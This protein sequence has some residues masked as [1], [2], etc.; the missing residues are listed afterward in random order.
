MPVLSSFFTSQAAPGLLLYGSHDPWLV[1]LSVAV[2]MFSSTM[3][4]QAAAQAGSMPTRA[5]RQFTLFAGALALGCGVWA[6]HFI[7]M[8]SFRLCTT[9]HYDP[10]TT[11]L[12][13]LPSLAA[14]W[15]ALDLLSREQVSRRQLG[16]G[17]LL[18]GGG[19]GAMHYIGM[20]A[21]QMAAAL[22]YDPL[23]FAVSIVVAVSLAVLALWV[24][25]GVRALALN[26]LSGLLQ[27]IISG[28]AMGLAIAGMHYTGMA[29]ARFIGPAQSATPMALQ[30]ALNIALS[31]TLVSF[32][33]TVLVAGATGLSRYRQLIEQLQKKGA[34]LRA[35]SNS[36]LD[37][38]IV[39]NEQG[40]IQDFNPGAQRIFG[41]QPA[42]VIGQKVSMLMTPT[43]RA[44]AEADFGAFMQQAYGVMDEERDTRACHRDQH[45]ISIRLVV[46]RMDVPGSALYVAFVSDITE[47]LRMASELQD[48]EAQFRSLIANIP[49]ISYRCRMARGWPMVFISDAV[50]GITGYPAGDFLGPLASLS[51]TDLVPKADVA[52]VTAIVDEAARHNR[53]FVL[54]FQLRH[55]SGAM[56]WIWGHGSLIRGRDGEVQW[57][58]GVLLDI[59]ERRQMEEDLRLA[60]EKAEAAAEARS[61]FLANMSHEIRTPMNAIIGFTE[62]VLSSDLQAAQ[63]KQL[64][65]VHK[66]ARNLLH[67]LN[68][69]LDT[70]KLEHGAVEIEHID[71]ALPE[72]VAQ[73]CAEQAMNAQRKHL[74]LQ[75]H[76]DDNVGE[77]V[78]G[79]PHRLRQI[80][81]NLVGNAIKFTEAGS[82]SLNVRREPEGVLFQV[83]DTGIGIAPDRLPH[84]FDAFTQADASMSRRYGGTGLGTTICKQLVA[85]MQGRI[86]ATSEPG[87]GSTFHVL[88]PLEAGDSARA[89]HLT[90]PVAGNRLPPMRVLVAD[91]VPQNTEL[92]SL[93]LGQ[94]G[95]TVV[96][97]S[98]GQQVLQLTDPATQA[99]AA[100]FDII[101]MD[102]QMPVMNGL[103]ACRAL[104]QREAQTGAPRTPVLALTANVMADD[105]HAALEAGMDGFA[106]KPIDLHALMADMARLTGQALIQDTPAHTAAAPVQTDAA[107]VDVAHG[108]QR[109]PAWQPYLQALHAFGAAQTTWLAPAS[110]PTSTAAFVHEAHRIKGVAANL[111]LPLVVQAAGALEALAQPSAAV[112]PSTAPTPALDTTLHAAWRALAGALQTTLAEIAKLP[113]PAPGE[114]DALPPPAMDLPTLQRKLHHLHAAFSRGECLDQVLQDVQ[115]AAGTHL[116]AAELAALTE[117]VEQF[118]F[119]A[120]AASVTRLTAGLPPLEDTHAP[121]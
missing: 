86:W 11:L 54:E 107:I 6:M 65:T 42:E 27:A 55:R 108:L 58:D 47:R 73:L 33:A 3:G 79:D 16:L 80:L 94:H 38:I 60:K 31:I 25:F 22:R 18:V 91:D 52:K 45:A 19:I 87:R 98:D 119:D 69:I 61:T 40:L 100:P 75:S 41:W 37:G 36:A 9:V 34:R 72:L 23:M 1:A 8:L 85:L 106:S 71:F 81:L 101:L 28:C 117:A 35:I 39:F 56:R 48:S 109:W 110:A 57:I 68:D 21:M 97:A 96:C 10:R 93:L 120:A 77:V 113:P 15:V 66:A 51:L 83:Q 114:Q 20:A 4:L 62:V 89:L 118:D 92:I 14:S 17:G 32:L 59:T 30:D 13:M 5:M 26:K 95:H 112:E 88:I 7:G 78:K 24:R 103:D 104:R 74:S 116:P 43:V 102:V 29:A 90:Q 70:S 64:T 84:I 53:P 115:R 111:A 99:K 67:L 105:R 82:V 12:S 76:V 63:R 46:A 44:A 2:A 50:E 49:G 121:R